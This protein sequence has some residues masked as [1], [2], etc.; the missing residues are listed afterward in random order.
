MWQ[1]PQFVFGSSLKTSSPVSANGTS[2]GLH[3]R[4]CS[5]CLVSSITLDASDL[6]GTRT[7]TW[8]RGLFGAD[9]DS[10]GGA[11]GDRDKV[12][13]QIHHQW[14]SEGEPVD[15]NNGTARKKPDIAQ[16]SRGPGFDALDHV[17][18]TSL[19]P[20]EKQSTTGTAVCSEE[21]DVERRGDKE[22]QHGPNHKY[23]CGPPQANLADGEGGHGHAR[24]T[25]ADH[26]ASD[27]CFTG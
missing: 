6:K 15:D 10:G 9:F 5:A 26:C 18:T 22:R 25:H 13:A 21:D 14:A 8:R 1:S 27:G 19:A 11:P 7:M 4:S 20:I 3:L 2:P 24:E 16:Q 12:T 17:W 23:D